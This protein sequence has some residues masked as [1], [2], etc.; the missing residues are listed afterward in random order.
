MTTTLNMESTLTIEEFAA[1][2]GKKID[3]IRAAWVKAGN[4]NFA[5]G[6]KITDVESQK[7]YA[8][9]GEKITRKDVDFTR[10]G[11]N[12]SAKRFREKI[13]L[14][15]ESGLAPLRENP[16]A[17]F[18]ETKTH[19][20]ILNAVLGVFTWQNAVLLMCA[21]AV[22]AHGKMLIDEGEHLFGYPGKMGALAILFANLAAMFVAALRHLNITNMEAVMFAA[23]FDAA[24]ARIHFLY[25]QEMDDTVNNIRYWDNV[26]FSIVVAGVAW[27]MVWLFRNIL[28]P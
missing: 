13:P 18:R 12:N 9:Y 27:Y 3:T 22:I 25:F 2:I 23:V 1:Q 14:K 5:K 26:A 28:N 4:E 16:P 17:A 7:I 11:S 19:D 24:A 21:C 10:N 6:R 20:K 15:D 8:Y